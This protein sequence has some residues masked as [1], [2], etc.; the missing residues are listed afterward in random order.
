M[1]EA[2]FLQA[3]LPARPAG[4]PIWLLYLW[5]SLYFLSLSH[6][7]STYSFSP[8]HY[9]EELMVHSREEQWSALIVTVCMKN[10]LDEG[11]VHERKWT[12]PFLE[13][14]SYCKH[15]KGLREAY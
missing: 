13:L 9:G 1:V 3:K 14:V 10:I 15:R 7:V 2:A 5:Y 11:R 12:A 8:F 6:H 4:S